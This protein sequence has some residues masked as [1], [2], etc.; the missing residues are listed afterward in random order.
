[1]MARI[2]PRFRRVEP[3]QRAWGYLLG[4]LPP[5]AGKNSWASDWIVARGPWH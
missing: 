1:M 2:A 5:L 4:L 3:R